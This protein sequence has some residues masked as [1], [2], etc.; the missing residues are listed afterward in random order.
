M[1]VMLKCPMLSMG[2]CQ[3]RQQWILPLHGIQTI[4]KLNFW[5][6]LCWQHQTRISFGH[7]E[8]RRR[9]ACW[10][11]LTDSCVGCKTQQYWLILSLST[12]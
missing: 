12:N 6:L 8:K 9:K 4:P 7:K 11:V 1:L 2:M 3:H 5:T 10:E